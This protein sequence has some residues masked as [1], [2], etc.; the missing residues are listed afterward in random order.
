LGL[1][2]TIL[3]DDEKHALE[4]LRELL[5]ESGLFDIVA[6]AAT[7]HEAFEL[8]IKHRP[9]VAFLD[10]NMP[11]VSVFDTISS[12]ND[13]PLVVFQ[14]AYS[15]YAID[16]FNINA[17]DY[18][19][20]PFS[21]ERLG[22]AVQKIQERMSVEKSKSATKTSDHK[23]TDK[24]TVRDRR[25]IKLIQVRDIQKICFEDGLCFIYSGEKKYIS[26]KP[27]KYFE[28][29][30]KNQGFFR[31]SRA[32]M[33]NLDHIETIHPMFQGSYLIELKDKSRVELSRRKAQV[34][35]KLIEF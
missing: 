24:I 20:K 15:E 2:K 10:I 9:D 31:T 29:K 19:M 8:I 5:D 25:S 1:I 18:L 23:K 32:Y 13:P 26:D 21:R 30:L 7:G 16:A 4:R 28:D 14:T 34:L 12:L 27:L 33:V 3:A 22:Q 35:K 17:I 6:E 11:G